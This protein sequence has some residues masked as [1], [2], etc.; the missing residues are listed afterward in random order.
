M[1]IICGISAWQL[2]ATAPAIRDLSNWEEGPA[3]LARREAAR[4]RSN[5]N[6]GIDAVAM[7][8]RG[9]PV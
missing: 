3:R 9:H 1:V 6:E 8:L 7:R 2:H 5:A 4:L